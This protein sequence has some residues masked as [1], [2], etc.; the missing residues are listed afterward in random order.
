[1]SR[2]VV[3]ATVLSVLLG[4]SFASEA[5]GQESSRKDFQK[6]CQAFAGRWVG[7]VTLVAG[8]PGIGERGENI[9]AYGD[10]R[11][12]EDGNALMVRFYDLWKSG[13]VATATALRRAQEFVA[14]HEKWSHPY[15]WAAWQLWGLPD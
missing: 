4:A 5:M 3:S 10:N 2:V 12:A 11:I 7:D 9:T 8:W 13:D 1:M 15:Y 6:L 14:S